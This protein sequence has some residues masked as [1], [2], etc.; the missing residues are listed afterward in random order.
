M[1]HIASILLIYTAITLHAAVYASGN[2]T[3]N[4]SAYS[5]TNAFMGAIEK[6][7]SLNDTLANASFSSGIALCREELSENDKP[8]RKKDRTALSDKSIEDFY[9][10]L[11]N[12]GFVCSRTDRAIL[13]ADPGAR[14]LKNNP[15]DSKLQGFKFKGSHQSFLTAL[16]TQLQIIP[17][18]IIGSSNSLVE[19]SYDINID[20]EITLR[21]LLMHIAS[22]YGIVWVGRIA[23]NVPI[24]TIES[25]EDPKVVARGSSLT[26]IFRLKIHNQNMEPM[27]KTP[28]E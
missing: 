25:P 16:S 21:E 2:N 5:F 26:L 6:G 22:D 13:V 28:A 4:E 27:L 11:I 1:K 17:P 12:E 19:A 10:A 8:P 23:K 18:N 20:K 24:Y 14:K 3:V 15:L 9:L 7:S